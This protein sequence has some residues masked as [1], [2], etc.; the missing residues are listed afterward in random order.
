MQAAEDTAKE[1]EAYV[2]RINITGKNEV[3]RKIQA[4]CDAMRYEIQQ[5]KEGHSMT[6]VAESGE[7]QDT[8]EARAVAES[9]S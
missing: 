8:V 1:T 4:R 5:S 2:C 9:W 6:T 3:P 7:K